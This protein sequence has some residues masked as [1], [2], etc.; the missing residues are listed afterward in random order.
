M[1]NF[2]PPCG[3]ALSSISQ[4]MKQDINE[5]EKKA[6]IKSKQCHLRAGLLSP[7]PLILH[8]QNRKHHTDV[9]VASS[10]PPPPLATVSIT[11]PLAPSS[12]FALSSS[13]SPLP[14]TPFQLKITTDKFGHVDTSWLLKDLS[15]VT[16]FNYEAGS[17]SDEQSYMW[18]QCLPEDLCYTFT[19]KADLG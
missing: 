4:T 18:E 13:V 9:S 3:V 5:S 17:L 10:H 1:G 7:V 2:S 8:H 11:Q 12:P 6:A 19:I 16:L 14:C 15:S